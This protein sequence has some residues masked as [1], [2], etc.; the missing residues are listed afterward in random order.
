VPKDVGKTQ[1]ISEKPPFRTLT[2]LKTGP[3]TNHAN[4]VRTANG[5]LAYI[6]IGGLNEVKVLQQ[7]KSLN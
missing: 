7:L 4:F 2:V 1:V 3:I 5:Q 6:T